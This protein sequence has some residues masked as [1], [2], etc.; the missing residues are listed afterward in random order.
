MKINLLRRNTSWRLKFFSGIRVREERKE[1]DQVLAQKTKNEEELK[2]RIS[3]LEKEK[4]LLGKGAADNADKSVSF[5]TVLKEKEELERQIKLLKES[6][7]E[8]LG[9]MY[10]YLG[11]AYTQ[12]KIYP[13]A[14]QAYATSLEYKPDNP[15]AHCNLGLLYSYQGNEPQKALDHLNQAL[16][17]DLRS[18]IIRQ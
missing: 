3:E 2:S 1:L 16:K 10:Y 9:N 11:L 4:D 6:F 13:D 18:K 12:A 8:Q 14:I 15:Q 5:E 17:L 7:Q